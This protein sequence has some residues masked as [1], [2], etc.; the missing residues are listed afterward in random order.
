MGTGLSICFDNYRASNTIAGVNAT[1]A[2]KVKYYGNQFA[3]QQTPVW[4]SP[5]WVQVTVYLKPDGR[6]DLIVDVTNVFRRL[7]TA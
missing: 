5:N 7:P 2:F 1:A 6:L 4:N 3:T